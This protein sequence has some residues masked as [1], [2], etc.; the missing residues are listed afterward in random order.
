MN[1]DTSSRSGAVDANVITAAIRRALQ[2][3]GRARDG[4]AMLVDAMERYGAV[5]EDRRK[6]IREAD[7]FLAHIRGKLAIF[8]PKAQ[9]LCDRVR[10]I[11]T[12]RR[13]IPPEL[14]DKLHE[15]R[16]VTRS[17]HTHVTDPSFVPE[18]PNVFVGDYRETLTGRPLVKKSAKPVRVPPPGAKFRTPARPFQFVSDV[19]STSG[20]IEVLQETAKPPEGPEGLHSS[21][22]F[23]WYANPTLLWG[24][25]KNGIP[26]PLSDEIGIVQIYKQTVRY[27][28][29]S[30][31]PFIG[32]IGA[33]LQESIYSC[34]WCLD[35]AMP[36][37]HEVRMNTIIEPGEGIPGKR[38]LGTR[39]QAQFT[40]SP[41][42]AISPWSSG[43]SVVAYLKQDFELHFVC[44]KGAEKGT[45]YGGYKWGHTFTIKNYQHAVHWGAVGY[46][47]DK[48]ITPTNSPSP[49]WQAIWNDRAP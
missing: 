9:T 48:Y 20:R 30:G 41:G 31:H 34:D 37:P 24:K 33:I 28:P 32:H 44:L 3:P 39:G 6:R 16:R 12:Y 25:T 47:Y 42:V 1:K 10:K 5:L 27:V 21:L 7:M 2:T 38:P 23:A 36:Y 45:V 22:S 13:E 26:C 14:H 29:C 40:D 35:K 18:F 46:K 8:L 19:V 15:L 49:E 17:V 11:R 43:G 4:L